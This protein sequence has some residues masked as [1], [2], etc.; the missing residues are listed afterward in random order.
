MLLLGKVV[1]AKPQRI[2]KSDSHL[3]LYFHFK[4]YIYH[5]NAKAK[6]CST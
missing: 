1:E 3:L 2:Y 6:M 5:T 4:P